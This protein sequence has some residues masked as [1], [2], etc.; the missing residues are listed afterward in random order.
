MRQSLQLL[1]PALPLLP[2]FATPN[3]VRSVALYLKKYPAGVTLEAATDAVKRQVFDPYKL[4]AYDAFGLTASESGRL[5][6]TAAGRELVHRLAPEVAAFRILLDRPEPYRQVLSWAAAQ[7]TECLLH[8]EVAGYWHEHF[9]AALGLADE[10]TLEGYTTC[11]F[12]LCQAAA[13]GTYITGRKGQP[14][15]L[16]LDAE[17]LCAY[18]DAAPTGHDEPPRPRLELAPV[19]PRA[20]VP[21][22]IYISYR[23]SP[24]LATQVMEALDL[25]DIKGYRAERPAPFAD[26]LR[27]MRACTAGLFVLTHDDLAVPKD[28]FLALHNEIGAALALFEGRVAVLCE[29]RLTPPAALAHCSCIRVNDTLTWATGTHLLQTLKGFG[30]PHQS[31][32]RNLP[33]S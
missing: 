11:F 19:A 33:G 2:S 14:S 7:E 8:H 15:R 21:L 5:R 10:K 17:E 22:H 29:A 6:L 31:T 23:E 16:R 20:G 12:Q 4:A 32:I 27:A 18:L 28:H 9:P 24:A 26:S 13:L 1:T 3:D 30:P 25:A